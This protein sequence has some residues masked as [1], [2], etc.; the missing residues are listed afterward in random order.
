MLGDYQWSEQ[1]CGRL[2]KWDKLRLLGLLAKAKCME[3]SSRMA[4][5]LRLRSVL[6]DADENWLALPD[7]QLVKQVEEEA[8]ALYSAP[9]LAHCYRTYFFAQL[10]ARYYQ[11]KV[12][13]ELLAV[14]SLLHD[15][16][17]CS[18][19][20]EQCSHTGFQIIG[21]RH[22]QQRI[23]QA[24]YSQ[25]KQRCAYEAVSL[26]LNLYIRPK[27]QFAEA[28]VLQRGATLDVIGANRHLFAPALLAWVH[29]YY[30]RDGFRADILDTMQTIPHAPHSHAGFLGRCGFAALAAANPLDP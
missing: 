2:S 10:F 20:S 21:A 29:R 11:L 26:H 27:P 23:Q 28:A 13:S 16:G 30:A 3:Q 14:S 18:P 8:T 5:S 15:V 24:G 12:D 7:S 17:L 1:T 6:Q 19:Y 25:H 22:V 9:M 4:V